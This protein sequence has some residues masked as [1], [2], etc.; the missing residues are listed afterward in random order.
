MRS[1]DDNVGKVLAALDRLGLADNTVVVFTSD[2]GGERFSDMWPFTG[3]KTELLEG[4]LRVPAI[5]RWPGRSRPGAV[6][7]AQIISMDWLPTFIAAAGGAIDPGCPSDGIDIYPAIAGGTLPERTLFWRFANHSQRAAR[8]GRFK[9]LEIAGNAFLFDVVADPMERA[10][11]RE[12][13]PAAFAELSAAWDA[14]NAGMLPPD[15]AAGRHGFTGRNLAEY[16]GV[17]S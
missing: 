12:R 2:N 8:R 6:S 11:L 9:L 17:D 13:E 14:W 4:G 10:N 5:V 7:E 1:L 3:R 15:P 16:F